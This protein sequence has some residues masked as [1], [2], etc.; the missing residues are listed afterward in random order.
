[1]RLSFL[2]L[3]LTILTA[4][5]A[6]SQER[7][8]FRNPEL[9]MDKRVN[10]LVSRMTLQEKADQLLYNAPAIPRLGVPEYNW[11]NEAL[12][13][14][15]RSGWATVFPQSI[16]LAGSWNKDLM[17]EIAS[18]ISDEARAKYHDYQRRGMKGIYQ[19]LTF[20]SP[21]I[22]IFRDPR[23][24]RGHETYGE[25]PYLTGRL[26]V[27]FVKGLQGDDPRYLKSVATAKHFAVHSGPEPLR[28]EF[29][30]KISEVDL[31]ETYLPA[32]RALVVDGKVES[33]MGAYNQFR[34]HPCCANEEL[35]SILY[36][37]WGFNGYIVS[38]CWAIN[39]FHTFQ[40]YTKTPAE[41][42]AIAVKRGTDLNCGVSYKY[43]NSAV[44]EGL[45]TEKEIDV[46]LKRLIR[47]RMKLGMFDPDSIVGYASI[48][49]SAN[50]SDY[51]DGL[52]RE[53]ARESIILLKNDGI[54]PLNKDVKNILVVGPNADNWEALLGNYNGIPKN[55]HT[56][57][58][59]IKNKAGNE[60]VI[61]YSEG[62]HLAEGI[63]N[64][65]PIPSHFLQTSEGK[66]GAY[67][68]YFDN[69]DFEGVPVFT[70]VDE[71]I[72]FYWETISPH[73]AIPDDN[74]SVRWTTWLVPPMDG[75]YHI[76]S[77]GS[78]SYNIEFDGKKLLSWS[79]EHH[80]FQKEQSVELEE[81]KR[82]KVVVNYKNLQGD[83][84][85]KLMWSKSELSILEKAIAKAA[86]ADAIVAVVGLSQRLEGEQ[87]SIKIDGFEGGD[88]TN[89]K[90]PVE[91]IELLGALYRT[92]K[93]VI[94]V[95]MNGSAL[96]VNREQDLANAVLYAGYGGQ[97]GGN[98][99]ADVLFGDYNPAGRLPVTWYKSVED[100][101]SFDNYDMEGRTYRY[102]TKEPLYP[103]GFGLSY[104]SFEYSEL[105]IPSK[106]ITGEPLRVNVTVKNSGP[107]DGDEVVQLYLSDEKGSTKRPI[108]QLEG[109]ERISLK[110]GESKELQFVLSLRQLSMIN[111]S[112]IR[113]IEPGWFTV[114]IGGKQPGF[115]GYLN[116]SFTQC[117]TGRFKVVGKVL[118][119]DR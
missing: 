51:A 49:L 25:D 62:S 23:W 67:A 83:A 110:A 43:L 53:A 102:F 103:F 100:L 77:W 54:L 81:G 33:I 41:S 11:W 36:D 10:D 20:W 19:G 57:L 4:V 26:G 31:R 108:R 97:Q 80:A 89:L 29:N 96:A 61:N 44:V 86:D 95:L 71:E 112:G 117:L 6:V 69:P 58:D 9:S 39:D 2:V 59:G 3:L 84:D 22:N 18:V 90:L 76:G 48:P 12:H 114:S 46:S 91:Q 79:S 109:F 119:V 24:G 17:Y 82:Y 30:A 32:F 107:L 65:V 116:P 98:A 42:A 60:L 1:M 5:S 111:A 75:I 16:T 38:D 64:L 74:F 28:H 63:H 113:V 70:R 35:Y 55:P 13:G 37:E 45:I 93:P 27:E 72:N 47:A 14:V 106:I 94:V 8:P 85:I 73:P 118:S 40:G 92:G 88:R 7:M 87:M 115:D 101:P 78:S 21:N 56:V 52:A 104:T 105:E 66:R 34:D 50:V 99:L 68:E 15:A